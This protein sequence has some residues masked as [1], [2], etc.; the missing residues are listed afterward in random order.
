MPTDQ[1]VLGIN[2][3]RSVPPQPL[4]RF[5]LAVC[6]RTSIDRGDLEYD[7]NP[8]AKPRPFNA[9]YG[10]PND[11]QRWHPP[12]RIPGEPRRA[13]RHAGGPSAFRRRRVHYSIQ[14]MASCSAQHCVLRYP[15]P[16]RKV[17]R[18]V[19]ASRYVFS[20]TCLCPSR[21]PPQR[22]RS[23][24]QGHNMRGTA[25]AFVGSAVPVNAGRRPAP[26]GCSIRAATPSWGPA[27]NLPGRQVS[28]ARTPGRKSPD[29]GRQTGQAGGEDG[30]AG[31]RR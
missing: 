22:R 5:P 17:C 8:N 13:A 20:R 31:Q 12:A 4:A 25:L 3:G 10:K 23:T 1:R 11:A 2:I 27:P 21:E 26:Q 29:R 24:R 28:Y 15:F 19:K 18:N 16:D 7:L 6:D 14:R 30:S 9:H